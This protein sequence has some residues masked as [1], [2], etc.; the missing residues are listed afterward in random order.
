MR[1]V[2]LSLL[3]HF[4]GASYFF[5]LGEIPNSTVEN[6]SMSVI[7][8]TFRI[9]YSLASELAKPISITEKKRIK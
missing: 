4:L 8:V 2:N 5:K 9:Q 6:E 3:K 7:C 1:L